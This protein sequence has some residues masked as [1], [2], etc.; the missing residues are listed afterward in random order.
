M[1]YC[2]VTGDKCCVSLGTDS[3][4]GYGG[5]RSHATTTSDDSPEHKTNRMI[6]LT[7]HNMEERSCNSQV[8]EVLLCV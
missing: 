7:P 1:M 5:A 6:E 3:G 4:L 8:K 2:L